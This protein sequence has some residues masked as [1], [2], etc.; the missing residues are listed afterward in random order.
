MVKPLIQEER[1]WSRPGCRTSDRLYTSYRELV[2]LWEFDHLVHVFSRF[3]KSALSF[4]EGRI[5]GKDSRPVTVHPEQEFGS[6]YHQL[7][8]PAA[9]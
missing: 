2:G 5:M 7:V 4:G 8:E 6:C 3:R 9:C 1:G